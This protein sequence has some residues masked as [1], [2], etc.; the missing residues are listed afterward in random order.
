MLNPHLT[1]GRFDY[2]D[3][4]AAL[5]GKIQPRTAKEWWPAERQGT[6]L[7]LWGTRACSRSWSS[8][9]VGMRLREG[10]RRASGTDWS[11][12]LTAAGAL[13]MI[14]GPSLDAESSS[15]L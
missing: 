3:I 4:I 15:S 11:R 14:V 9:G 7:V 10:T 12:E 2:F 5:G 1:T 13:G 8:K 6:D